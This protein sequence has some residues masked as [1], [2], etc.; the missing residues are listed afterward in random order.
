[1]RFL[2][3]W[4]PVRK[5][6]KPPLEKALP[7]RWRSSRLNEAGEVRGHCWIWSCR[8]GCGREA[9]LSWFGDF[10]SNVLVKFKDSRTSLWAGRS[11]IGVILREAMFVL[12]SSLLFRLDC[13]KTRREKRMD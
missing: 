5:A 11:L 7:F 4:R 9:G 6:G 3:Q 8:Q 12:S 2:T 10:P 13:C 1:M